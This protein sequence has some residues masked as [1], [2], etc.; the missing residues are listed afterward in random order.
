SQPAENKRFPDFLREV[1]QTALEAFE[2]QDYPF[3]ELVDRLG[4]VRD[5]SRNPLFDAMF[6]LQNTEQHDMQLAGLQVNRVQTFAHQVSIFDLTLTACESNG[7]IHFDM[8]FSTDLF[9]KTTIERWMKHLLVLLRH[10]AHQPETELAR[11]NLLNDED[12]HQILV[13]FNHKH[14]QL[15]ERSGVFHELFEETTVNNPQQIAVIEGSKQISYHRLNGR[16]NRLARTLQTA[17]IG[18]GKRVA[19]LANRSIEAIIG[20]LAVLKAGGAYIPIDS[21]YPEER[22]RFLLKDSEASALLA[23]ADYIDTASLL[24][25]GSM[26]CIHLDHEHNGLLEENI[27]ST[28]TPKDTAYV[29]YTSGTT[30]APK[31]VEVRHRNFTHAAFAW[32]SIYELDRTPARVLQMASFSFDVFSGDMA[33]AFLNGG[34]LVICPDD[35]RIEPE[36]LCKLMNQQQITLMESTPALI[37][38]F[39]EYVYRRKY[40]LPSLKVLILGSDIV[41]AQDFYALNERFGK[42]MRIINSYGVT[43][44]TIDSSYYEITMSKEPYRDFVPIGMPLPNVQMYVLNKDNQVQ[45]IGVPGELFIGGEG[46]AKGYWRKAELTKAKFSD[47]LGQGQPLY[48]TG[49]QA[50][51]LPDGT[52]RLYGRL[53]QQV[54][55]KG[56]RIELE[57]IENAL[58]KNEHVKEA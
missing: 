35:V 48:Q 1:R 31:G 16:A 13:E 55:I 33:R 15:P 56:Y 7:N 25:D 42:E 50:C 23:Q 36:L 37:I 11:F 32:R 51:W 10:I 38:P 2:H 6:I 28:A 47:P 5:M 18:P 54:K 26:P 39:M 52:L 40:R 9:L 19:I 41:S 57:E 49:D 8:E 24:T 29:I 34:T 22:I 27:V 21:H 53:D 58:L 44:A 4:V 14:L 12:Q 20:V 30:G 45:P 3:E 43:E 17:G 46:V